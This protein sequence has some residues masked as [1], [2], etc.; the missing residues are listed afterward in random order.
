MK[1]Y[2]TPILFL[3]FSFTNSWAMYHLF[4]KKKNKVEKFFNKKAI[5]KKT[6]TVLQTIADTDKDGKITIKDFSTDI[7]LDDLKSDIG[8]LLQDAKSYKLAAK[9]FAE[10][11]KGKLANIMAEKNKQILEG[12]G[13]EE[14]MFGDFSKELQFHL[15][16]IAENYE[17]LS[18][19]TIKKTKE[20][21]KRLKI[22][23]SLTG[24]LT[25][26]INYLRRLG[27]SEA[28][29]L[30][31]EAKD[32]IGQQL[33]EINQQQFV[34]CKTNCFGAIFVRVANSVKST[35]D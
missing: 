22:L 14:K 18:K 5:K 1:K 34:G 3:C 13:L 26:Y 6:F 21:K 23:Q 30:L 9:N 24:S 27:K 16:A 7:N 19:I 35:K 17:E 12:F 20:I 10:G 4:T 15:S 32:S 28:A 11:T 29:R 33:E 2:I 31:T 8:K 25:A